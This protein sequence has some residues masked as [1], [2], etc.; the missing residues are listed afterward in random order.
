M[1][2]AIFSRSWKRL[3][4]S[5]RAGKPVQDEKVALARK[6]APSGFS[7]RYPHGAFS[8]RS[9]RSSAGSASTPSGA[10]SSGLPRLSDK[11]ADRRDRLVRR[12]QV[13][14][15]PRR[16]H[17]DEFAVRQMLVHIF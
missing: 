16:A 2:P 9:S 8:K 13:W 14:A 5:S 4:T 7:E 6:I 1:R 12:A 3:P 15:M 11:G 10:N 17:H